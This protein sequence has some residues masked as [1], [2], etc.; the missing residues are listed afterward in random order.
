MRFLKLAYAALGA[1]LALLL[2][3]N[4]GG[5]RAA[6]APAQDVSSLDRRVS[7]MEQRLY[8]IESS[9]MQLERLATMPAQRAPSAAASDAEAALLRAEVEALRRR[10]G[11][12][13]CGVVRLDERTTPAEARAARRRA[14][15]PSANDPCRLNPELPLQLSTRP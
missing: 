14:G 1:A 9:L 11:E 13:E 15:A 3:S 6:G 5:S 10:L 4:G 7:M 8:R 12:V 2:A